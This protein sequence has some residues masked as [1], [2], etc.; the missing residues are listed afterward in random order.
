MPP[1]VPRPMVRNP[2]PTPNPPHSDHLHGHARYTRADLVMDDG[3]ATKAKRRH[4]SEA[5]GGSL[6]ESV[7]RDINANRE[8]EIT[9]IAISSILLLLLKHT[10]LCRI[11]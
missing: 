8:K 5:L 6:L 3:V 4:H 1:I 2:Q 11:L 10:K 7:Q 9:S